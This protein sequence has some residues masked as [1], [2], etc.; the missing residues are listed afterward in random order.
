MFTG[1]NLSAQEAQQSG[2]VNDVVPL[3]EIG[4]WVEAKAAE[5]TSLS[6]AALVILKRALHLGFGAWAEALPQV[7]RLYLEELMSTADAHEGVAAFME[8]RTPVWQHQ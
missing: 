3:E 6:R 4:R 1:R 7:E 2:L 5:L 8:K